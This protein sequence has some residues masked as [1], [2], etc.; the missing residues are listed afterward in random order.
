MS[1]PGIS[2]YAYDITTNSTVP[3]A[4][5]LNSLSQRLHNLTTNASYRFAF[6]YKVDTSSRITV[7]VKQ[8]G[9]NTQR[10]AVKPCAADVQC[11][12]H[13]Q[14]RVIAARTDPLVGVEVG[15]GEGTRRRMIVFDN[16]EV[17][18]LNEDD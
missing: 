5:Q 1:E 15:Y 14:H 3:N 17:S 13:Y 18:Y 2:T 4:N 9:T 7:V 6:D 12:G 8:G 16:F 11:T 10:Y